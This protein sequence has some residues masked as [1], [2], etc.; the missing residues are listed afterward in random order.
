MSEEFEGIPRSVET[1][2]SPADPTGERSAGGRYFLDTEF[3][4]HNGPLLSLALVRDDGE[5]VH[6]RTTDRATDPWVIVNV[7]PLM[8]SHDAGVFAEVPPDEVG[9]TV[10]SFFSLMRDN[11]PTIIADSVVDI[12]RFC[13]ALSTGMD[14]GWASVDYPLIRFE[15]HDVAAYP[16][17]VPN[18]VQH[19]AWWDAVALG[20]KLRSSEAPPVSQDGQGPRP[21]TEAPDAP[22]SPLPD[23]E[24]VAREASPGPWGELHNMAGPMGVIG[25]M[26]EGFPE[27]ICWLEMHGREHANARFIAT[28][29]PPTVLHLLHLNGALASIVREFVDTEAGIAKRSHEEWRDGKWVWNDTIWKAADPEGFDLVKRAEA[30]LSLQEKGS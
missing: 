22:K 24:R 30:A 20:E 14:G 21:R 28:F 3:D 11:S 18:A 26:P 23:M 25:A 2:A 10:A 16:T 6:V 7:E 12:G 4:G 17:D 29:D 15:V 1:S 19:N 9:I 13:R 5:S 8:D 27:K